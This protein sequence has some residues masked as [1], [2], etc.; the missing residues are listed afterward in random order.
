MIAQAISRGEE[1]REAVIMLIMQAIPCIMH[2]KN[3]VGEKLIT[4]L[5][6]M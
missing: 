3:R 6:A 4:A 5:L 1:G 2:L